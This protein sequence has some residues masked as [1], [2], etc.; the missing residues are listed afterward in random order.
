MKQ[1]VVLGSTGNVGQQVLDECRALKD[2]FN[3]IAVSGYHNEE[4]LRQ[5]IEEFKPLYYGFS[6]DL[7]VSIKRCSLNDLATLEEADIVIITLGGIVALEPTLSA[8]KAHKRVLSSNKESIVCGGVFINELL[9]KG[10]GSLVP[11]DSEHSAVYELIQ[12]F[13]DD[14]ITDIAITASGGS[15][16]D[17]TRDEIKAMDKDELYQKVTTNP[18]WSMSPAI[19]VETSNL[20]NKA[21]EIIEAHELFG[22]SKDHIKAYQHSESIIHGCVTLANHEM[23]ALESKPDM[24]FPVRYALT[25][26]APQ[27][28]RRLG[29]SEQK[30]RLHTI[31]TIRHP[32]MTLAYEVL[33]H[34][35]NQTIMCSVIHGVTDLYLHHKI[36]YLDMDDMIINLTHMYMNK[37]DKYELDVH[38]IIE[39]YDMI[40]NWIIIK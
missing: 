29:V 26:R 30:K 8:L 10:Y 38:T 13:K 35:L 11:L 14:D 20:G 28:L 39:L 24:H 22:F 21:L 1:V 34:P 40:Y 27:K 36:E 17:Y 23:W 3:V 9:Q 12:A 15:L 19:T 33:G 4:L 5:Q 6:Q 7:D 37:T 31:D 18:N 16:R 32:L 2:S 25:G